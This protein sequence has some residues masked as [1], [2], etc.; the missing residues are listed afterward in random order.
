MRRQCALRQQQADQRQ[1]A[2]FLLVMLHDFPL[3]V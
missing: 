2:Q 3:S 1:R